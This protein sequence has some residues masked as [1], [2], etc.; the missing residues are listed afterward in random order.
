MLIDNYLT[1]NIGA[2]YYI[3]FTTRKVPYNLQI[4]INQHTRES[5]KSRK[6]LSVV[7]D[8]KLTFRENLNIVTTN[9]S[10]LVGLFYRLKK[11]KQF[12][13]DVTHKLYYSIICSLLN[14]SCMDSRKKKKTLELV[15]KLKKIYITYSPYCVHSEPLFR[16]L[17]MLKMLYVLHCQVSM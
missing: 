7:F 5:R 14:Y 8:E 15:I 4:T 6:V 2:T 16:Q 1:L 13:L 9:I 17:G 10:K 3:V 12:P 11:K